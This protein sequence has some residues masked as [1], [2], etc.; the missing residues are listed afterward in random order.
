MS[1]QIVLVVEDD[2]I[3]RMMTRK[4]VMQLGYECVCVA[5]GEEAVA[6]DRQDIGLI[7]M[8]IGLPGI[9][10]VTAAMMI[11]E[12]ELAESRRRVP[13]IGLTAHSERQSCILAGMD[14][15]LQKPAFLTDMKTMLY[16]WMP[17]SNADLAT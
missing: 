6:R 11:R 17:R 10:G 14:D 12:K 1:D 13:I 7:F 16:K 8:D 15:F 4:Q 9:D 3:L 5:S 2:P